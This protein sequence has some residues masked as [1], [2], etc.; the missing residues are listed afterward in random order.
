MSDKTVVIHMGLAKTGSTSI[1]RF[2]VDNRTRLAEQGVLVPILNLNQ[3]EAARL[4]KLGIGI[5]PHSELARALMSGGK[6][7]SEEEWSAWVGAF[8]EFRRSQ[9]YH[10]LILSTETMGM[11][12][13]SLDF[14]RLRSQ[15]EGHRIRILFYIRHA[16][17]W[18][19]SLYEQGIRGK[20]RIA[21]TPERFNLAR[22]FLRS[23]FQD[24]AKAVI[25]AFPGA[26]IEVAAFETVVKSDGLLPHFAAF[27][28][29]SPDMQASARD[30]PDANTGMRPEQVV[31]LYH[32]NR[33]E[34][35][36]EDFHKMRRSFKM[37][38]ALQRREKQKRI[39]IFTQAMAEAIDQRYRDDIRFLNAALGTDIAVLDPMP[40]VE[41]LEPLSLPPETVERLRGETVPFLSSSAAE[42]FDK[43][44]KAI[45]AW[46]PPSSEADR[47]KPTRAERAARR[48]RLKE[49]AGQSAAK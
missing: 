33:L 42:A 35:S 4:R 16:E 41:G 47:P 38:N 18:L 40:R 28:G 2:L 14:T 32:C 11:R 34:I 21:C 15:L 13:T 44:A 43:V 36:R 1:Q 26:E 30:F 3:E 10:T 37:A 7:A 24:I 29:L 39:S 23:S 12:A 19:A 31:F 49:R 27:A 46:E 9:A 25:A 17:T 45:D 22:Q 6:R 48:E 20:G 5:G 8:E